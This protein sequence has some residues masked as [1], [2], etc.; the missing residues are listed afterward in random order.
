M[1]ENIVLI[2]ITGASGLV[3]KQVVATA[4]VNGHR[5][6]L[7]D[8]YSQKRKSL[9]NRL[10][11]KYRDKSEI[12][13][14]DITDSKAV[15]KFCRGLD[16]VIHL[17]AMIPPGSEKLPE[18]ARK[19][20]VGGTENI[21]NAIRKLGEKTKLIFTSSIA[22][23]GDRRNSPEIK[24]N[25]EL[26]P[27][28][29]DLYSQHKI[30]AEN[31]I[32]DKLRKWCILRLTYVVSPEK[33]K[34]D[35]LMF[36]MPLET[37]IEVCHADDVA[38]ALIHAAERQNVIRKIFNIAGGKFCRTTYAEYLKRMFSCFGLDIKKLPQKAFSHKDFH[39]GFMNTRESQ[40]ILSFQNVNI[41]E[42]YTQ[43]ENK[44][45]HRRP[46]ITMFNKLI[47]K[48]LLRQS[49]YFSTLG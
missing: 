29:S 48:R 3:G 33:L 26:K 10:T 6:R 16:T 36:A 40:E 30:T 37:N 11:K 8:L 47:I 7:F 32:K 2:G 9:L 1:Q 19:I 27:G 49:P 5:V 13:Y 38:T 24:V 39:C 21:V 4:L 20:N 17:A 22:V 42:Y 18:L 43:V 23:Y 14:G 28:N 35:P 15:E 25:D 45:R 34:T 12:F 44:S 41:E 46:I 31:I